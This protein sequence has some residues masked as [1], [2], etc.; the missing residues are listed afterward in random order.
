MY[1]SIIQYVFILYVY[2]VHVHVRFF[3]KCTLG[4]R[5][6]VFTGRFPGRST[7][8]RSADILRLLEAADDT[9]S[10]HIVTYTFTFSLFLI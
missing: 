3:V 2:I 9:Y 1:E 6:R 10:I 7:D 4:D 5:V 8:S